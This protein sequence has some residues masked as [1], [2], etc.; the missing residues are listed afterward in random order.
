MLSVRL[1]EKREKRLAALAKKTGRTI[2]YYVREAIDSQL[3]DLED[4]YLAERVL[5]KKNKRWSHE[6]VMKKFELNA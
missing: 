1:D 5:A 3:E 6:D 4:M 2:S